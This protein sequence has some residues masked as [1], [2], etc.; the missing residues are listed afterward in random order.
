[1]AE[2]CACCEFI[3]LFFHLFFLK[4]TFWNYYLKGR[5]ELFH[6]GRI[7]MLHFQVYMCF[8]N[9]IFLILPDQDFTRQYLIFIIPII[10]KEYPLQLSL[11]ALSTN[12]CGDNRLQIK[13]LCIVINKMEDF[14]AL[15]SSDLMHHIHIT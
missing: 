2:L 12:N 3:Q 8:Q 6:L 14:M 9:S 11:F 5:I 13:H 7:F 1:M 10:S 15:F 4:C